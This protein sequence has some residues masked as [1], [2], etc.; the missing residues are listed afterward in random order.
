MNPARRTG[1]NR[2][3][4]ALPAA[5][6]LAAIVAVPAA[7]EGPGG[8]PLPGDRPPSATTKEG[9]EEGAIQRREEWFYR[10][11]SAGAEGRMARKR[12]EAVEETK[13]QEALLVPEG[14]NV[15]TCRGPASSNFGGWTFGKVSG[16]IPALAKDWANNVLYVGSASGG[17]WKSTDDGLS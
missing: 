1:R 5:L 9:G 8:K 13:R 16:R 7:A 10:R 3:V 11:R 6:A 12:F 4:I 14:T 15:W 17:V 2:S